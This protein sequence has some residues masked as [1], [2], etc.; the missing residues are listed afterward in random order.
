MR[1]AAFVAFIALLLQGPAGAQRGSE[2]FVPIA[3]WYGG[4]TV[5]TPM[6]SRQPEAE[7]ETWRKDLQAI[8]ALGF[9]SIRTWVDWGSAEPIRGTFRF[10]ALDQ[11]LTLADEAG[12]RVI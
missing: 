11:M 4:S 2:P 5:R 12:L 8:R 9:N 7:R 6:V 3:V 10:E 1:A